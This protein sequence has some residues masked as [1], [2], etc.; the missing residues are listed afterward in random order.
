MSITLTVRTDESLR[1]RLEER[2]QAEGRTVSEL[3][4][5]ILREALEEG[6]RPLETR[7]GHLRG[8]LELRRS[9]SEAWRNALRERNW[10]S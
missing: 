6:D 7:I 5:D 2:A 9:E 10:R 3:V 4:R 1:R 8:R